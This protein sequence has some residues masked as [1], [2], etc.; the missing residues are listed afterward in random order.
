MAGAGRSTAPAEPAPIEKV[1]SRAVVQTGWQVQR[2]SGVRPVADET[3]FDPFE[4]PQHGEDIAAPPAAEEPEYD[5]FDLPA[6]EM[7]APAARPGSVGA[8]QVEDAVE[9]GPVEEPPV[10]EAPIDDGLF[11]VQDAFDEPQRG[12]VGPSVEEATDDELN[13]A[14]E[15]IQDEIERRGQEEGD[16][17]AAEDESDPFQ[18]GDAADRP[19][20]DSDDEVGPPDV[21]EE[22]DP[23]YDENYDDEDYEDYDWRSQEAPGGYRFRPYDPQP[24]LTPEQREERRQQLEQERIEN[25]ETCEEFEAGV[26]ADNIRTVSLDIRLHGEAGEDYPFDCGFSPELFQ[27]RS[28]QQTT[29]LWKASGLCHKPLYFEQ[30]Q[31]ERYGHS[32]GPVLDPIVSGAHFFGTLPVLP[33]KMGITTPNECIYTLGYYR[34]GSCAPYMIPAVPFTW[35]AA[36]F[37]GA[38]WTTGAL[39]IP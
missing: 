26:K 20:N 29:F 15:A 4:D 25:D 34:P 33:Y 16:G 35:R 18:P 10:E 1:H 9:S 12:S 38:A 22:V 17:Q 31:M 24:E 8:P 30:V 7:P 5:P 3:E 37:E 28:W 19:R 21:E 39:V 13:E 27:P 23:M 6:E 11:E 2:T 14:R 32:W 36:A